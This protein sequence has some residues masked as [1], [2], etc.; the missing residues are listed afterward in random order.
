MMSFA[1]QSSG[2]VPVSSNRIDSGTRMNVNPDWISAA[3]S[4][5][6]TPNANALLPPPMHV[7]LSVAW[8]KSPQSMNSSRATWRQMPGEIPSLAL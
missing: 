6:P 7:W 8:M 1:V 3:Y 4:V 2:N 5:D